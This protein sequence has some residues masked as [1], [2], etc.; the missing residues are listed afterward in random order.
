MQVSSIFTAAAGRGGDWHGHEH[1]NHRRGDHFH[2]QPRSS[3]QWDWRHR[4][5]ERRYY[6][7]Y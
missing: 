2:R 1:D 7:W 3:W 4:R 5:W 6:W